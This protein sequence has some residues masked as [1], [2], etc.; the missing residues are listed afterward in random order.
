MGEWGN[1]ELVKIL[2]GLVQRHGLNRAR[3]LSAIESIWNNTV[4]KT[5][6]EHTRIVTLTN[7]GMLVVAVPSSVWSQ[8][9]LYYKPDILKAIQQLIPESRIKDIRTRVQ[10]D[11]GR[12]IRNTLTAQHSPYFRTYQSPGITRDL[13]ELLAGVQEK[14][15]AAARVWLEQGF[16]PCERCQAPTLKGYALCIVCELNRVPKK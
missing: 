14:Y 9:L 16:K 15:E 1:E 13:G 6:A 12:P 8:Q 3:W 4:G 7:D 2:D 10:A 11:I 5:V